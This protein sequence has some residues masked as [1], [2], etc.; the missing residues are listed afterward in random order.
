[1]STETGQRAVAVAFAVAAQAGFEKVKLKY[2]GGEPTLNFQRVMQI[3]RAAEECSHRSGIGLES[4]LLSNGISLS[5]P[6]IDYLRQ[7]NIELMISLDGLGQ[8]QN[9]QRQRPGG[10]ASFD[11]VLHTLTRLDRQQVRP[12]ISVTV[13][14]KNL[15]G[16]PDLLEFILAHNYPFHLNF[17]RENPYTRD[18]RSLTVPAEELVAGLRE[19]FKVVEKN[20]PPRSL[21]GALLDRVRL[22]LPHDRP[23]GA[24]Q[25]YLVVR[26]H[27]TVSPCQMMDASLGN[28]DTPG[29]LTLMQTGQNM[30][31]NL[32]V[33][34]RSSCASCFWQFACGGGCPLLT[35]QTFGRYDTPSP[36][37]EVYRALIPDVL[38]L[39]G[40][41]L[42]HIVTSEAG[43]FG[44]ESA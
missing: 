4:V 16:L 40:L 7:H 15:G 12:H 29:L 37:C 24:C 38:R 30:L 36:Y 20:L 11:Q 17:F 43:S 13:S 28:L 10:L 9:A 6:M 8:Y 25:S 35:F 14:R 34:K 33:Y 27:G 39:E 2:A 26:P 1:M 32:P 42:K 22:D 3:S 19:A 23:C 21:L 41:R 31:S 18:E 44:V 5:D